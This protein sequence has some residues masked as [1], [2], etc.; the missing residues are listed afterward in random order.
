MTF[1]RIAAA[2]L[3]AA[4][5]AGATASVASADTLLVKTNVTVAPPYDSSALGPSRRD[6][7]EAKSP[8]LLL[9]RHKIRCVRGKARRKGLPPRCQ[10]SS[11]LSGVTATVGAAQGEGDLYASPAGGY[12]PFTNFH[13]GTLREDGVTTDEW[14]VLVR[15]DDLREEDELFRMSVSAT[16]GGSVN[17]NFTI[18]DD[19]SRQPA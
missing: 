8:V 15:G 3:A 4:A 5:I 10:W 16:D 14:A 7:D 1:H 13:A 19:E 9:V 11:A 12:P 18:L 2:G 17:R 6:I